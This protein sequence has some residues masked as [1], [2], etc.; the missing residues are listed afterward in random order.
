[1]LW[2]LLEPV[3]CLHDR[4]VPILRSC[5]PAGRTVPL[6]A[7]RIYQ[8]SFFTGFGV[9]AIVYWALNRVFPVIGAADTFEEIDVSGYERT[10]HDA[11]DV[12]EV[13]MDTKD[14]GSDH[15]ASKK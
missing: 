4:D 6:A 5:F 9:S 10:V 7:T 8:L 12:E 14:G 3:S 13:D 11:R 15:S 1:M 2:V